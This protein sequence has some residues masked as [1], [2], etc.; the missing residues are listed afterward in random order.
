MISDLE[1]T[2]MG[3][4]EEMLTEIVKERVALVE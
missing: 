2:G 1:N 4:A 3:E